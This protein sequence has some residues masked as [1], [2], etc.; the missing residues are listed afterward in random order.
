MSFLT[1]QLKKNEDKKSIFDDYKKFK[2]K[3][4]QIFE[5]VNKKQ[6]TKQYIYILWQ[7]ES[8]VKYST[9]FQQIAAL[10]EWNNE[11]FTL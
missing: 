8:T 10:T 2:E 9:E 1:R 6:T 4:Q 5:I 3:L 11:A 7:N